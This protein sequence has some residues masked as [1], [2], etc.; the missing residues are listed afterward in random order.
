[1]SPLPREFV[2]RWRNRPE[3]GSDSGT[4][5]W[6]ILLGGEPQIQSIA[7]VAQDRLSGFHELH[8]T[9]LQRLHITVMEAGQSVDFSETQITAMIGEAGS[10]LARL[11]PIQIELSSVLYHPEAIMLGVQ[12]HNA[13]DGVLEA[14]RSATSA[15][16]RPNAAI[17]TETTWIPHM[18]LCYSTGRQSSEPIIDALGR[19][20]PVVKIE[21][22]RLSLVIQRG[23]ERLWDWHTVGTAHLGGMSDGSADHPSNQDAL[24]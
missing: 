8:M 21:I 11:A 1:V 24:H 20:V 22:D 23:P 6:H 9:P 7:K 17:D 19:R 16:T 5:Y 18:T 13:L 2:D 3:N 14:A 4:L 15:I 10:R 12:P